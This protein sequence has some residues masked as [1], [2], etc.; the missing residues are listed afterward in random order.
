MTYTPFMMINRS[1]YHVPGENHAFAVTNYGDALYTLKLQ[2][3]PGY[4]YGSFL[5]Y[6]GKRY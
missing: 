3:S 6:V 4:N 2:K 1:K 5:N